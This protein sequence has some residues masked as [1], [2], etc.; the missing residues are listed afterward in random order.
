MRF[1]WLCTTCQARAFENEE[2]MTKNSRVVSSLMVAGLVIFAPGCAKR[3]VPTVN[4]GPKISRLSADEFASVAGASAK[5][6]EVI[7]PGDRLEI[8]VYE[9]LPASQDVR[10]EIKR[11]GDDGTLF[12]LPVETVTV[13][14]L[15]VDEAAKVLEA[16][17]AQYVVNPHCEV[18]IFKRSYEPQVYVFGEV[19]SSGAVPYKPTYHLLDAVSAAGGCKDNAYLRSVKI[20]R[21]VDGSVEM[22]SVNLYDIMRKGQIQDNIAL[23][24]QDIV[25]IPRRFYTNLREVSTVVGT[26]L[27]WY[28]F[29]RNMGR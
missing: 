6:S 24:D 2:S 7:Y 5:R 16:A 22:Y 4:A 29:V 9:K 14:G 10:T 12:L 23:K 11:V 25:F 18:S 17:M 13:G 20:V 19:T 3:V 28:Y 15:T 26:L 8:H 27:P 21:A 1:A